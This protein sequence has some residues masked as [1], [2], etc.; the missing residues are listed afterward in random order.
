M[1]RV[2]FE[3]DAFEDR[4]ELVTF[5]KAPEM[6]STLHKAYNMVRTRLKYGKL[7]DEE[8]RFLEELKSV[9]WVEEIT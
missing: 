3:F 2:V 4:E 8:Y 9:L 6:A 5:R 1:A 7:P